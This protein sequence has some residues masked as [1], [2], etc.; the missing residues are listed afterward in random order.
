MKV[1]WSIA[2]DTR[3][4]LWRALDHAVQMS[5]WMLLP[6]LPEWWVSGSP[7]HPSGPPAVQVFTLVLKTFIIL[8]IHMKKGQGIANLSRK[9]R[10]GESRSAGKFNPNL[11]VSSPTKGAIL[12]FFQCWNIHFQLKEYLIPFNTSFLDGVSHFESIPSKRARHP[13]NKYFP[14]KVL[15]VKPKSFLYFPGEPHKLSGVWFKTQILQ[16]V[17]WQSLYF[18]SSTRTGCFHHQLLWIYHM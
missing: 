6:S 7:L 11:I 1:S 5:A 10:S 13:K 17:P 15:Q 8:C 3:L 2:I 12:N 9:C 4:V 18:P 16:P 14:N